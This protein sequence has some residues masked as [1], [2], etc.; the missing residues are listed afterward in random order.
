MAPYS[1]EQKTPSIACS[2]S[3]ASLNTCG[4]FVVREVV[5]QKGKARTAQ[6]PLCL[7][8]RSLPQ[9]KTLCSRRC[10]KAPRSSKSTL[11]SSMR[12]S[13]SAAVEVIKP[14]V[15]R[16]KVE[17][18]NGRNLEWSEDRTVETSKGRIIGTGNTESHVTEWSKYGKSY[19]RMVVETSNGQDTESQNANSEPRRNK[20]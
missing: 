7:A 5:E 18:P 9:C 20:R 12:G 1:A 13:A 16:Q 10:R 6:V 17:T 4:H 3:T 8:S 14:K 11:C 15:G 19:Y 2:A